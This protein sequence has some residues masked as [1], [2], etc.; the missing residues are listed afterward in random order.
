MSSQ[1]PVS[2]DWPRPT[3]DHVL[4]TDLHFGTV[5]GS[6]RAD[7]LAQAPD[8]VLNS[9]SLHLLRNLGGLRQATTGLA[10]G[11][12]PV[13]GTDHS[14]RLLRQGELV[15][16]QLRPGTSDAPA[17]PMTHM[18]TLLRRQGDGA[19]DHAVLARS[20]RALAGA[21]GVHVHRWNED[22]AL[23]AVAGA[24]DSQALEPLAHRMPVLQLDPTYGQAAPVEVQPRIAVDARA[25]AQAETAPAELHD[26]AGHP[27]HILS[28]TARQD[29]A[30]TSFFLDKPAERPLSFELVSTLGVVLRL[31]GEAMTAG[32]VI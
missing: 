8:D 20:L 13:E 32:E 30:F 21:Q 12:L 4:L 2:I 17:D 18:L 6:D 28:T 27:L 19:R 16:L 29:S 11:V 10:T 3:G 22:D 26:A 14:C 1:D 31:A 25:I 24:L 23:P 7:W 15:A 9:R 5:L